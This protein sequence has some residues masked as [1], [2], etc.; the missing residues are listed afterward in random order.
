MNWYSLR[1]ISGK[2]QK[3]HENILHELELN[4]ISS[5]VDQIFVPFEKVVVLKNNKKTIKEK[6]FFPGYI[7][8][9]M[10]MNKESRYVVEN[11]PNV[12]KFVGPKNGS[13]I[14]LRE[15]EIKRIFGEVERK[16]GQE[17]VDIPFNKNDQVTV[18]SGPFVDF[19][20][21]VEEVNEDKKKVKVVI[22]IFGRPT[23]IELDYFQLEIEK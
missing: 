21:Y 18:V 22:S 8:I 4:D 17:I 7:L 3:A 15:A 9:N 12:I 11:T 23:S 5:S 2:E 20:G 13:P 16:E 19:S 10:D 1:V 6:L 14:P